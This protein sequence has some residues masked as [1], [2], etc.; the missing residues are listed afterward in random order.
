MRLRIGAVALAALALAA[1][2]TPPGRPAGR[3][4]VVSGCTFTD[5][6]PQN[7]T[8]D[9]D[10]Q[11]FE[12]LFTGLEEQDRRTGKVVNAAAESITSDDQVTWTIKLR[13]G[14]TFHNGEPLTAHSF[15]DTWNAT[16][17]SPAALKDTL[18]W[19]EGYQDLNPGEGK[20]PTAT[21]MSGL[22]VLGRLTFQIRPQPGVE[23]QPGWFIGDAYDPLPRAFFREYEAG[24]LEAWRRMP[25]G[26]GPYQMVRAWKDGEAIELERYPGYRGTP[27]LADRI[28]FRISDDGVR[29][30]QRGFV[31]VLTAI[32]PARFRVVRKEY[33]DRLVERPSVQF[34][35]IYF[36]LHNPRFRSKALRQALSLALDR[37]AITRSLY[38]DVATPADALL[39]P[40]VLGH[41]DNTCLYCKLDIGTARQKL[42][43][44]GWT[45]KLDLFCAD[46]PFN[47]Q[48]Y[49]AIAAQWRRNLG[50][51]VVVHQISSGDIQ[52]DE[53]TG[54]G[55]AGPWQ[56]SSALDN[57]PSSWLGWFQTDAFFNWSGFSNPEVDRLLAAGNAAQAPGSYSY[58]QQAEDIILEDMPIIPLWYPHQYIVHSDRVT[59]ITFIGDYIAL[60]RIKVVD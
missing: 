41:R 5:L 12:V 1:A 21:T 30:L 59:N 52:P 43:A 47:L 9:C 14:W 17:A 28:E 8:W 54:P 25:I 6:I 2:C 3:S 48:L 38:N 20:E 60:E 27:G 55:F 36:P 11:L 58:F 46:G 49:E 45:G 57:E 56:D 40:A 33:G 34:S 37:A 35:S 10:G 42:A 15:V 44:S 51:D 4:F 16:A 53:S 19:I 23:I 22:E 29:D 31:D 32:D 18:S 7:Q 39:N 50:I 26:D 24:D 13:D